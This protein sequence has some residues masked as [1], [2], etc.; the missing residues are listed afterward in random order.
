MKVQDQPHE[1]AA[2]SPGSS[3]DGSRAGLDVLEK[4]NSLSL[5]R[6][7][8]MDHHPAVS[9]VTILT[10]VSQFP[11]QRNKRGR[12]LCCCVHIFVT[13]V[14]SCDTV[15]NSLE[16]ARRTV[17]GISGQTCLKLRDST[18]CVGH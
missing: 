2:F 1:P 18:N 12:S 6:K 10:A 17:W 13:W 14:L 9:L 3:L 16:Q 8:N 15:T 11:A 4:F 5:Y 7:S